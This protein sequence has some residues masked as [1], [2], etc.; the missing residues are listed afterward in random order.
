MP[1]GRSRLAP[2]TQ[3]RVLGVRPRR[4]R[5]QGSAPL[6]GC[7]VSRRVGGP[8]FVRPL[9]LVVHTWAFLGFWPL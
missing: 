3:R 1:G 2:S 5:C 8:R 9:H 6:R 4:D 7:V